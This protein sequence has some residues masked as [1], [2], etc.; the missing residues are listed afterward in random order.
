MSLSLAVLLSIAAFGQSAEPRPAFEITDVHS[1]PVNAIGSAAFR[2]TFHGGRY[3]AHGASMVDLIRTAYG[4]DAEKV[5][6]GPSWLELDHFEITALAPAMTSPDTL[7]LMLQSLLAD[8]FK[9]VV[10]NEKH[11]ACPGF[12]DF[13]ISRWNKT[14]RIAA[15]TKPLTKVLSRPLQ[16]K[17]IDLP[18]RKTA[19]PGFLAPWE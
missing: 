19:T 1:T 12:G 14:Q 6:G 17:K 7:K 18:S 13:A 2:T 5:F 15:V 9:L 11:R 16:E 8:R 10:H 4:V 3:E